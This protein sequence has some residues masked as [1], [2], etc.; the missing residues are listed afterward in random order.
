[1]GSFPANVVNVGECYVDRSPG[2]PFAGLAI[3]SMVVSF[4]VVEGA[5]TFKLGDCFLESSHGSPVFNCISAFGITSFK[6][7]VAK[8]V[9]ICSIFIS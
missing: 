7:E 2:C 9:T 5:F 4:H 6:D 8:M 1:M 3:I